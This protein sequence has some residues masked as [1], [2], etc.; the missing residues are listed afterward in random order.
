MAANKAAAAAAAVMEEWIFCENASYD[1]DF[2]VSFSVGK[3]ERLE[4]LLLLRTS[5]WVRAADWPARDAWK[6]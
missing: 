2:F 5:L 1:V 6:A 4:G 3:R